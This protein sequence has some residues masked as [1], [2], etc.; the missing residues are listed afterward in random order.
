MQLA[1]IPFQLLQLMPFA[2]AWGVDN[3]DLHR[4]FYRH[5]GL[6][7]KLWGPR[8]HVADYVLVNGVYLQHH[9]V[10]KA[11]GIAA[12]DVGLI[13]A[14][15]CPGLLE[16]IWDSDQNCRGYVM[17]EGIPAR[18]FDEVDPD[19][20]EM[21]CKRSLETGYAST[22]FCPKNTVLI[23]GVPSLIDIDTVPTR[24]DSLNMEFEQAGGCLR[25]HVFPAY[26]NFVLTNFGMS[27]TPPAT[28]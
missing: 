13:D 26:R 18:N 23:N 12:I 27:G 7:Y 11:S 19:F 20:V 9:Y 22:D 10:T 21:V 6:I 16:L 15:T 2:L 3:V 1:A 24:L 28:A 25:S 4:T 14:A 8:Y 17:R 5:D